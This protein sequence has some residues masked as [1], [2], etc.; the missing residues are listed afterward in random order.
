[1]YTLNLINKRQ[2][3][4]ISDT[5]HEERDKNIALQLSQLSMQL[6]QCRIPVSTRLKAEVDQAIRANEEQHVITRQHV[7]THLDVAVRDIQS[8]QV[9]SLS[10]EAKARASQKVLDR[11]LKSLTFDEMNLRM[12]E[13]SNIHPKT[14]DW[15]LD[16]EKVGSWDN[17]ATWLKGDEKTYWVNGKAGSG[18]STLMKFVAT[19]PKT[20][21]FLKTWSPDAEILVVTYYFWL[22][23][24]RSQRS[25]KGFL[26]SLLRQLILAD[27]SLLSG[28]LDLDNQL[29]AKRTLGD[30]SSQDLQSAL[31]HVV[32]RLARHACI[33][34]DGLDELDPDDNI[35]S[36]LSLIRDLSAL[37]NVKVCVSSR[38]EVYISK[39]L[40]QY[41]HL[42]LQDLTKDD[43]GVCIQDEI[44]YLCT[45]YHLPLSDEQMTKITETMRAKA[46]GVFLW[47]HFVLRSIAK[48]SRNFDDFEE[49]LG[50]IKDL[51]SGMQ[52][53]YLQMWKRLNGDEERYHQE[54]AEYFSCVMLAANMSLPLFELW[55][56]SDPR[57]QKQYLETIS[58][59][60]PNSII[61]GCEIL[62][63]RVLTRCAGL[64][65]VEVAKD[66]YGPQGRRLSKFDDEDD[67][68]RSRF[69]ARDT[70]DRG[71]KVNGVSRNTSVKDSLDLDELNRR[72]KRLD[73]HS[74]LQYYYKL[75]VRFIH[76]TALDFLSKT[77]EGKTLLGKSAIDY[78]TRVEMKY[79]AK[80]ATLIQGLRQFELHP[81]TVILAGI[82]LERGS[83]NETNFVVAFEKVC[84]AL[85]DGRM[86]K[87]DF[88]QKNFRPDIDDTW[89][90]I[91]FAGAAAT[92]TCTNYVRH[93]V[94]SHMCQLSP[95]YLGYLFLC[96][97]EMVSAP[98][99]LMKYRL[100]PLSLLTWLATKKADLF[101]P[102]EAD[103]TF[104]H[105]HSV[106][107]V[108]FL[109]KLIEADFFEDDELARQTIHS[110]KQLF[111]FLIKSSDVSPIILRVSSKPDWKVQ[112]MKHKFR[113][114]GS[115]SLG[116]VVYVSTAR[117]CKL[118]MQHLE[119][120]SEYKPHWMYVMNAAMRA[121]VRPFP[122]A[123][124][125]NRC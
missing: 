109:L 112:L 78:E 35:D 57:L 29:Y 16:A 24:G 28:L 25:L 38:P 103:T 21:D 119:H 54:A 100:D 94:E 19:H 86:A 69:P 59:R 118:A 121:L 55:V 47:V 45:K 98:R 56:A 18:K 37:P 58:P 41:R 81:V 88:W 65:E 125:R 3:L 17:F 27:K 93:H 114:M 60:D 76:R 53:V 108:A 30:W 23:G 15:V 71:G 70:T 75:N 90:V 22:S 7:K 26:S 50:R 115:E 49:L 101:S 9:E 116:L 77:D 34:V 20:R 66:N 96:A 124:S 80:I 85:S 44:Q 99:M 46:N 42:R 5:K 113:P 110:F 106:P 107:A 32:N 33:F 52:Q 39:Q 6:A 105:A 68:N 87:R 11:F 40:A 95:R 117:L 104:G 72:G 14:F 63:D 84:R 83:E 43:M 91:D 10:N 51:P 64:L 67:Q 48:G 62:K 102:H 2:G 122:S 12:N 120:A 123:H 111:P 1:M 36:L 79:I 97:A 89:N 73:D 31:R 8:S 74:R 82:K 92:W 13:V 4:Q 61:R